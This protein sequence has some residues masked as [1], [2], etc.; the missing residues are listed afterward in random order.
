[1]CYRGVKLLHYFNV[2]KISVQA[3]IFMKNVFCLFS[4]HI[5]KM[6]QIYLHKEDDEIK[7]GQQEKGF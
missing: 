7:Y 4:W 5:I 3:L 1:M 2:Y 6:D